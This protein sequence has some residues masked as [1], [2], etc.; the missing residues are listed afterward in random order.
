MVGIISIIT[1]IVVIYFYY[2]SIKIFLNFIC[3]IIE[4]YLYYF[5]CIYKFFKK[6]QINLCCLKLLFLLLLLQLLLYNN[7]FLILSIRLLMSLLF[8]HVFNHFTFFSNKPDLLQIKKLINLSS[9]K[10]LLLVPLLL[11]ASS[12]FLYSYV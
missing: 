10:L 2:V 1:V 5:D 6:K 9:L 4:N 8:L 12:C 3:F 11:I 7:F